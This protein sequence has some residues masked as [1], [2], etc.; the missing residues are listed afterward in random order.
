MVRY[1][2]RYIVRYAVKFVGRYVARFVVW[3]G[4][5]RYVVLVCGTMR[6]GTVWYGMW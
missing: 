2:V 3:Y 6:Y 1:R 4:M 5:V